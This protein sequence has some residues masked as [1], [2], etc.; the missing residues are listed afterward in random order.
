MAQIDDEK[1]EAGYGGCQAPQKPEPIAFP[2]EE[3]AQIDTTGRQE[4]LK[5]LK[6]IEEAA[7]K[8]GRELRHLHEEIL[9][10]EQE[11]ASESTNL[12]IKP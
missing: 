1:H 8:N 11:I 4:R 6:K 9:A 7:Q 5:R 10:L 3:S 2:R 12:L